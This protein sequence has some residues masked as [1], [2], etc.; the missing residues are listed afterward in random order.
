MPHH[1]EETREM[2]L[3]LARA[4]RF[5]QSQGS[6][7]ILETNQHLLPSGLG[8][9]KRSIGGDFGL[10]SADED[11]VVFEASR[12]GIRCPRGDSER[13]PRA[14]QPCLLAACDDCVGA[15]DGREQRGIRAGIE[16]P[17]EQRVVSGARLVL[18]YFRRLELERRHHRAHG[19]TSEM[20]ISSLFSIMSTT[21]Q[22]ARIWSLFSAPP[23]ANIEWPV[24]L[25]SMFSTIWRVP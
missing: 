24:S 10:A 17:R 12:F 22:S 18:G 5:G 1:L 23:P 20:L 3:G 19:F 11:V 8:E 13:A 7:F 14:R 6:K 15:G 21:R 4:I 25:P 16:K 9:I 2:I